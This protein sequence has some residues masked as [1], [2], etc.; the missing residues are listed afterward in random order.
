MLSPCG[1][2]TVSIQPGSGGSIALTLTGPLRGV[3]VAH[4]I[5]RVRRQERQRLGAGRGRVQHL[6][7]VDGQRRRQPAIGRC[8]GEIGRG[9][10]GADVQDAGRDRRGD[11]ELPVGVLEN[12][13]G[14]SAALVPADSG[15]RLWYRR[16]F[17][18]Q[19]VAGSSVVNTSA[20]RPAPPVGSQLPGRASRASVTSEGAVGPQGDRLAGEG[21][22]LRRRWRSAGRDRR[23]R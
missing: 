4:G 18:E 20:R 7:A 21:V 5:A 19:G 1:E 15:E 17:A 16:R 22:A 3:E 23:T 13:R 14:G 8:G 10:G 11:D 2:T 9:K 6:H 12:L